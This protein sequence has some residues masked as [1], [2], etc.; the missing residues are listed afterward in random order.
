M[1]CSIPLLAS[2][3]CNPPLPERGQV[4]ARTAPAELL[5]GRNARPT[6]DE[7]K[8]FSAVT[9][10]IFPNASVI[11]SELPKDE[12]AQLNCHINTSGHFAA[13]APSD[14]NRAER[15]PIHRRNPKR[16]NTLVRL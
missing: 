13:S 14:T 9:A 2:Q 8:C 15:E 10:S 3:H 12:T 16:M 6:I 1:P 5:H 11:D 7:M 4:A